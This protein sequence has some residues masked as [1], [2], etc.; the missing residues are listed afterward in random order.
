[1]SWFKHWKIYFDCTHKNKETTRSNRQMNIY[2]AIQYLHVYNRDT[3]QSMWLR[4]PTSVQ[5]IHMMYKYMV[6][7]TT[8]VGKYMEYKHWGRNNLDE[9]NVWEVSTIDMTIHTNKIFPHVWNDLLNDRQ[10][11]CPYSHFR[12]L[13]NGAQLTKWTWTLYEATNGCSMY[14]MVENTNLPCDPRLTKRR[15]GTP[16]MNYLRHIEE[17][18]YL[19]NDMHQTPSWTCQLTLNW[20]KY[21][22]VYEVNGTCQMTNW[23]H[24]HDEWWTWHHMVK[25]DMQGAHLLRYLTDIWWSR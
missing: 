2:I 13:T 6:N 7:I 23:W 1:M 24:I 4:G 20:T 16:K 5:G 22:Y 3:W 12:D 14:W 8:N 25:R 10:V 15:K 11:M 21:T 9:T 18:H 17:K 19:V